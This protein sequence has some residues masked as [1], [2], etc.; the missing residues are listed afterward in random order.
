MG[1]AQAGEP[2]ELTLAPVRPNPSH[3]G[4]LVA[5]VVLPSAE[6]ARLELLDVMG[7][8]VMLRELG[9]F[10]VGRHHVDLAAERRLSPGVYL[11]RLTQG[12][13]TRVTRAAVIE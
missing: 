9:G 8:R 1:A 11:L 5:E 13:S 4:A 6:P 3:G 2:L 10:S 12:G 7:R